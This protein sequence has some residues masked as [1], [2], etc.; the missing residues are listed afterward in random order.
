[1]S[2]PIFSSD[3]GADEEMLLISG[4]VTYGLGNWLEVAG[5]VGTR[6]KEECERHYLEVY[7]GAGLDGEDLHAKEEAVNGGPETGEE[8]GKRRREFMPVSDACCLDNQELRGN[9]LTK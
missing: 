8:G 1:L 3:W 2:T 4:L 5:H 9:G 6:T 7:L